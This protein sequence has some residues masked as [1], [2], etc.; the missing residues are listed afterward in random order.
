MI[1][2]LLALMLA[3]AS[4]AAQATAQ[5]PP[6][7]AQAQSA[8]D[9]LRDDAK[10]AQLIAVLD[11]I[12]RATA[13]PAAPGAAPAAAE[14]PASPPPPSDDTKLA[15]PLAPDSVGAQII[16]SVSERL[17]RLSDEVV[18]N[19]EAIADF[20]TLGNWLIQL[21]TNPDRQQQVLN[22]GWRLLLVLAAGLLAE[23][24][25]RR[26]LR[27]PAGAL[28]QRR[29]GTACRRRRRRRRKCRSA[30]RS[31]GRPDRKA[32]PQAAG[33]CCCCA[34][35]LMRSAIS[36]STFCRCW[37]CW[38]SATSWPARGWPTATPRAW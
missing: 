4:L 29:P 12:A 26:A 13:Q 37:R 11:A 10:R 36:C 31:R 34:G 19:A 17:S 8:L 20:R 28:E 23:F 9:V 27:R 33:A 7:R 35:C 14:A 6:T 2:F 18:A 1:R 24:A 15:I 25:T 22:T 16:T 32:P 38:R 30:G 5:A 21:T 3:L